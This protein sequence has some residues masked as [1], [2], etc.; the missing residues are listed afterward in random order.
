MKRVNAEL[1]GLD[2]AMSQTLMVKLRISIPMRPTSGAAT[3]RTRVANLSLS[4]YICSTVKVPERD[5]NRV[6]ASLFKLLQSLCN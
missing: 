3:S 6:S 5:G 1:S 2:V 4:W